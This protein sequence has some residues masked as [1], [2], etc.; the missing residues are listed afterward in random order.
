ML[1]VNWHPERPIVS[2]SALTE[3]RNSLEFSDEG[4]DDLTIY[5]TDQQLKNLAQDLPLLAEALEREPRKH[6]EVQL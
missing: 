1:S 6:H 2:L 4:G 3:D 5:L